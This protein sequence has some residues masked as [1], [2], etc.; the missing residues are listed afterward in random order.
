MAAICFVL[1]HIACSSRLRTYAN[2]LQSG[3]EYLFEQ[4]GAL[5][6]RQKTLTEDLAERLQLSENDRVI[7]QGDSEREIALLGRRFELTD[8]QLKSLQR[9]YAMTDEQLVATREQLVAK[10]DEF[11][12]LSNDL[13]DARVLA[14]TRAR[15]L[16]EVYDGLD[17]I[18]VLADQA[19]TAI[20]A[21]VADD[22]QVDADQPADGRDVAPR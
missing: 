19:Y 20:R 3:H 14:A 4:A 12:L 17:E 10:T 1:M 18:E 16:T 21:A 5:L 2:A 8:A 7:L 22:N 15:E 13:L 9:Q 11:R 6:V